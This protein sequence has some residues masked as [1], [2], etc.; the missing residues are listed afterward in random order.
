MLLSALECSNAELSILFTDDE[1]IQ[2][3]NRQYRSKDKPTD[4]LS[5]PQYDDEDPLVGEAA[6]RLLLGDVVISVVTAERQ[7]AELGATLQEELLRLLIHG[8]LHLVG[9]EHENVSDAEADR[10]RSKEQD[11][12]QRTIANLGE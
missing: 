4:V 6:G 8:V 5:F 11:L 3:L 10:M 9:Y 7:A 2:L 12:F 1:E